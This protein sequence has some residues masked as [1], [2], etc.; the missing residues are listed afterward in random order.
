MDRWS[1]PMIPLKKT[2]FYSPHLKKIKR[3]GH[4]SPGNTFG[5]KN[6]KL[7][8]NLK[9]TPSKNLIYQR[10]T[11]KPETPRINQKN[12]QLKITGG[13]RGWSKKNIPN[14]KNEKKKYIYPPLT[15]RPRKKEKNIIGYLRVKKYCGQG[16][17]GQKYNLCPER[18]ITIKE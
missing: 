1:P 16:G 4:F 13:T 15:N 3:K 7:N 9:R 8:Q 17:D 5:S 12:T 11:N 18:K 2:T 14:P 10:E 6:L